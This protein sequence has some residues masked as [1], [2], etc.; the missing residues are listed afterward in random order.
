[1]WNSTLKVGFFLCL[2]ACHGIRL[3]AQN[4]EQN[5]FLSVQN[6]KID[7]SELLG[8]ENFVLIFMTPDC[9]IVQ[10]YTLTMNALYQE[11]GQNIPFFGIIPSSHQN[12]EIKQVLIEK[13]GIAFPLL[14]DEQ[15]YLQTFTQAQITPECVVFD[16]NATIVYQG[17]INDWFVSVGKRKAHIKS[18][19]L[20]NVLTTLNQNKTITPYKTQAIGCLIK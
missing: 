8:K 1:M 6:E 20:K 19:D 17:R 5:V 15:M 3:V 10:K 13:F 16:K 11:F 4:A 7:F 18:E 14:I 12:A 9:P 2:F